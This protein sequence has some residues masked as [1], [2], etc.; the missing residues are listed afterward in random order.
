MKRRA[1]LKLSATAGAGAFLY[2][3]LGYIPGAY[4]QVLLPGRSIPQFVD[5]LPVLSVAGGT[6]QTVVAGTQEVALTMREFQAHMLPTG[7]F[8]PGVKPKT[9]VWG[10]TVE[11]DTLETSLDTYIGPVIVAT[12]GTP[13]QVRW[14]NDLPPT[15]MSHLTAWGNATDQTLHWADP[16]NDEA[17]A[18]AHHIMPGMPPSGECALNYTG[19]VPTVAHLHGGE[20]PP[21]I[22]GGPDAWFTSDGNHQGHAFYTGADVAGEGANDAGPNEAIYRYPNTQ[23]AAP[24]WFHD[25][26]LGITRLNVYAGLAGAYAIIDAS[27]PLPSGLHPVG[28]QQGDDAGTVEYLIPLVIQDRAFD[29]NG[30]LFYPNVGL[31]PEHPFWVPEFEGDTIV[32]NGRVWPYLDVEPKRYR[33]LFINGS[34][35]RA[36]ELFL[37]DQ[38]AGS[39]GPPLWQIA[40]DGG[41]LDTPV[42]IDASAGP[43]TKLLLL[44][45]ERA[46]VIVDFASFQGRTLLLRNTG[47]HPFPFGVPPQG[48]TIGRILQ[49]RVGAGAVEDYSYDP[50][51][52]VPL[53]PP[54]VRLVDPVA[55]TLNVSAHKIRQLTLNEVMGP[56]GPL[57]VLLNNTRWNGLSSDTDLFPGGVRG[58]FVAVPS[59]GITEYVSEQPREGETELW[60]IVNLTADA[61]P[62]HVHLTQFQLVNRQRFNINRY[63]QVYDETFPDGIYQPAFG[64]PLD[65]TTGNARALGGNPDVTSYLQGPARPP[66]ANEAGWK[67]TVTAL[68]GEVTRIAIRFAPTDLPVH[69]SPEDAFYPFDPNADGHGYV[70]HCHILEHEDNEMMRPYTVDPNPQ[71]TRDYEQGPDY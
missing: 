19:P 60:E 24:L 45:G 21:A 56:G 31:N 49:F 10:Y 52:G 18:C 48:R 43:P 13:T 58:D 61:H 50:A 62:I 8:V 9:W 16:L 41:Y 15:S 26:A 3:K 30:E 1:F 53:R 25:H 32:V 35:A 2:A 38:A 67:D 68:P 55:G 28:L 6:V 70:W 17:N 51:S 44:P 4:G 69:T 36:Y 23:E 33:F 42:K 66:A 22:D 64:P 37:V 47:R 7:T 46:D 29:V 5:P 65:Y 27:L 34:N 39:D 71:A 40:T 57:E 59:D 12:R 20:I 63:T 11:S 54:M 14:V